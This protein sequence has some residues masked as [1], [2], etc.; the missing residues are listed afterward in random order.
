MEVVISKDGTK[1]AYYT[2]NEGYGANRYYK[3]TGATLNDSGSWSIVNWNG[4]DKLSSAITSARGNESDR[5]GAFMA[6]SY[7]GNTV[8]LVAP[9]FNQFRGKVEIWKTDSDTNPTNLTQKG[10]TLTNPNV[11]YQ[12]G[13]NTQT[14]GTQWMGIALSGDGNI[15]VIGEMFYN[16]GQGRFLVYEY[17]NNDLS[18]ITTVNNHATNILKAFDREISCSETADVIL[19]GNPHDNRSSLYR[20]NGNNWNL[21]QDFTNNLSGH[22]VAVND[23]GNI[24]GICCVTTNGNTGSVEVWKYNSSTS[25]W[26]LLG[27]R[28]NGNV[29]G[30]PSGS[31][32]YFGQAIGLSSDGYKLATGSG[33]Y[34]VGGVQYVGGMKMFQYNPTTDLWDVLGNPN[35]II[36]TNQKETTPNTIRMTTDGTYVVMGAYEYLSGELRYYKYQSNILLLD[37]GN[38]NRYLYNYN[39][40]GKTYVNELPAWNNFGSSTLVTNSYFSDIGSYYT[41]FFDGYIYYTTTTTKYFGTVSDDD[42]FVWIIEED[43]KWSNTGHSDKE[44]YT[45]ISNLP[46]STLVCSDPNNH[47]IDGTYTNENAGQYTFQANTLYSILIKVTEHAGGAGLFFGISD[48]TLS[49]QSR[50]NTRYPNEFG[51]NYSQ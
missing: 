42:S 14:W 22:E 43:K 4:S 25:T 36:G 17:V 33:H 47:G 12:Y 31:V 27:N 26:E 13:G 9:L 7:N 35:I 34:H 45:Y 39:G 40:T 18:L 44:S 5:L 23:A 50:L 2:Q 37:T 19:V 38:L 16:E 49:N 30:H 48:S 10:S 46:N 21:E 15:V 24:I 20:R 51:A 32:N 29:N 1:V 6:M 3:Y 28:I 8:A 41:Y 11:H